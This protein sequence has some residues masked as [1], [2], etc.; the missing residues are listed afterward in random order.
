MRRV[1]LGYA[2]IAIAALQCQARADPV[3]Q[4][5]AA[6][7]G[8]IVLAEILGDRPA[9]EGRDFVAIEG[10][11]FDAIKKTQPATE[12]GLE[13]HFGQLLI[14]KLKPFVGG[15]ATT[16]SSYYGY[17]GIRLD[18]YWG[19]RIVV[20]PSFAVVGYSQGGGK[21]LGIPPVLGRFGI[22]FQYAVSNDVR[23]GVA[24]HHMSNGKVLGQTNNPGTELIGLTVSIASRE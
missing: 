8:A 22:D 9:L 1:L 10:G 5:L 3:V 13:Y 16:D 6:A 2:A 18:S 12:F 19:P 23:V 21:N 15:G 20:T 7:S 4:G 24:L 14:W 17:G 11:R